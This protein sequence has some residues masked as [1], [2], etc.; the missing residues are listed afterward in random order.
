MVRIANPPTLHVT[1][2]NTGT[3]SVLSAP[4]TCTRAR[5]PTHRLA[6]QLC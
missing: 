2:Y 6:E 3:V 5:T 4:T 1:L